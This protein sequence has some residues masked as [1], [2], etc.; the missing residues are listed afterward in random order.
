MAEAPSVPSSA[1]IS[2]RTWWH[3]GQGSTSGGD[4]REQKHKGGCDSFC[5]PVGSV[6]QDCAALGLP[7]R[8][9]ACG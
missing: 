5:L 2:R 6:H 9:Q 8:W 3:E 1:A 7:A 4:K